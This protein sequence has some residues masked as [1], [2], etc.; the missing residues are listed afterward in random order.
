MFRGAKWLDDKVLVPEGP[1]KKLRRF[2]LPTHH[3]TISDLLKIKTRGSLNEL[4]RN[5]D[6][7]VIQE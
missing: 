5:R 2:V 4:C 1:P 6:F 3:R 7:F